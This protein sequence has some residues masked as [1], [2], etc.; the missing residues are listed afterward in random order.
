[1]SVGTLNFRSAILNRPM[2]FAYVLPDPWVAGPGPYPVFYLLHGYCDDHQTWLLNTRLVN[3]VSDLPLMVVMPDG[4]H[5]FYSDYAE[6]PAYEQYLLKE[7]LATVEASFNVKRRGRARVIGGLSMGG[8]GAMKLGLKYPDLFCSIGAHSSAMEAA[9]ALPDWGDIRAELRHIFGPLRK[10]NTHREN[11]DP[12]ALA[13]KLPP[14]RAPAIYF[15]CGTEDGLLEGNRRLAKHLTRLGIAH[16][17]RE[18]PGA[19]DWG[20]WDEHLRD[21]LAFHCRV[22]GLK[23]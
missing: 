20:Y 14:Q 18:F 3:Y 13:E 22:L 21:S 8:F 4:E 17:Y 9:R 5:S 16:E 23:R 7:V 6:G 12:F 1:M 10:N 11:S 15:D 19:H 2:S